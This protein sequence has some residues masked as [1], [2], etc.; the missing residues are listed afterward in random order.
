MTTYLTRR[1]AIFRPQNLPRL[2]KVHIG[3]R[4]IVE[5]AHHVVLKR[6]EKNMLRGGSVAAGIGICTT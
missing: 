3:L 4:Y 2:Y 1:W 6:K 5:Y